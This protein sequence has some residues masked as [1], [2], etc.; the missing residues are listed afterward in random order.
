MDDKKKLT[1]EQIELLKKELSAKVENLLFPSETD[2]PIKTVSFSGV[3]D[4]QTTLKAE[5]PEIALTEINFDEFSVMYGTQKD[6]QNPLQREFAK[7][8][9]DALRLM[10]E[11]LQNTEVFRFGTVR[12]N[13]YV[14]GQA[15]DS[16]WVG[17]KTTIVET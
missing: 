4:I 10:S 15:N 3:Q 1:A 5:E 6:W 8:F 14:V 16:D 17:L 2:F 13:I 9:G 12:A 7:E 11:Q